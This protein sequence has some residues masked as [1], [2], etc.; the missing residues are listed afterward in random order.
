MIELMVIGREFSALFK[1][2]L[3]LEIKVVL[4]S[5]QLLG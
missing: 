2:L 5:F 3:V 1:S 4:F